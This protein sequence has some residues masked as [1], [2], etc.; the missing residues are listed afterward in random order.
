MYSDWYARQWSSFAFAE[1][2]RA[3][4]PPEPAEPFGWPEESASPLEEDDG[5]D[6][7]DG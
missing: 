2:W 1:Q 5:E 4:G 3:S 7:W 6:A